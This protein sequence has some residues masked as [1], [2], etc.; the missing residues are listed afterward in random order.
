[1]PVA[2]VHADDVY[3][4]GPQGISEQAY[5]D[6]SAVTFRQ[7]S[8]ASPTFYLS[9]SKALTIAIQ[10]KVHATI[11]IQSPTPQQTIVGSTVPV[12]FTVAA[13]QPLQEVRVNGT[14]IA[15]GSVTP[16]PMTAT[17]TLPNLGANTIRIWVVSAQG[18][19]VQATVG[20]QVLPAT[21][22]VIFVAPMLDADGAGA[23]T[24]APVARAFAETAGESN[25]TLSATVEPE[26]QPAGATPAITTWDGQYIQVNFGE[27]AVGRYVLRLSVAMSDG[28]RSGTAV[29][30]IIYDPAG[31]TPDPTTNPIIIQH[32]QNGATLTAFGGQ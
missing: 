18:A 5:A 32:P 3:E 6:L 22:P 19:V 9:R 24:G 29:A 23:V 28:S 4:G 11:A 21:I 1:V 8:L 26:G 31:W 15:S 7:G 16:G 25:L 10:D 30:T 13:D 17:V 14:V 12:A 27:Q 20:V 2:Y